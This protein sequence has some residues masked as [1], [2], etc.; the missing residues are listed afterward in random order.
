MTRLNRTPNQLQALGFDMCGDELC[1]RGVKPGMTTASL[2]TRFPDIEKTRIL[3]NVQGVWTVSVQLSGDPLIVETL[4][5]TTY[6]PKNFLPV[7][8]GEIVEQFGVPC[9]I[10]VGDTVI[11]IYQTIT[12][13]FLTSNLS[14][15]ADKRL[16]VDSSPYVFMM[17]RKP[18][19]PFEKCL[20]RIGLSRTY[21]WRGFTSVA[22]Y[23]APYR[24]VRTE[25]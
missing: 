15:S 10:A 22:K 18:A 9:Q 8:A 21:A 12:V 20:W 17:R 14:H 2:R 7:T 16:Q 5:M 6:G 23:H 3:E 19:N 1:W 25:P 4:T 11:P 13:W 24:R